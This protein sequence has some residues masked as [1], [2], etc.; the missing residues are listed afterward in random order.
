M[1]ND[2][3]QNDINNINNDTTSQFI[4]FLIN[5]LN[6]QRSP[7]IF[8]ISQSLPRPPINNRF[9]NTTTTPIIPLFNRRNRIQEILQNSLYEKNNTKKILSEK[10]NNQLKTVVY[11]STDFDTNECVI[12]QEE[13]KNG[14]EIIQLPCKHIFKPD[15]IKTWLKEESSKCPIC[16]F[17]LDFVE[18]CEKATTPENNDISSNN[19]GNPLNMLRNMRLMYNP[20]SIFL[21]QTRRRNSN[22]VIDNMLNMEN[23]YYYDRNLQN[24]ILSSITE[25]QNVVLDSLNNQENTLENEIQDADDFFSMIESD[26]VLEDYDENDEDY[27]NNED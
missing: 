13:F 26:I 15:A 11:N 23:Q 2:L 3:S 20:A 25:S 6:E 27:L 14:E 4:T 18:K 22:T 8:D 9:L 5:A 10:G 1:S 12:T 16:R 7:D 19:T 21:P 17:E 24:A